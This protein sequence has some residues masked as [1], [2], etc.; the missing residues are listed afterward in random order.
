[1]KKKISVSWSGGKDS[2]FALYKI[3][4]ADEFHVVS[5]HTVFNAE[6]R[7]VGMHGV[8]ESLIEEQA[9]SLKLPLE[10]LFLDVSEDHAAYTN[11]IRRYYQKC[12]ANGVEGVVFG[13]IFLEDLKIFRDKL[14]QETGLTG[15][16]PLWKID[17]KIL[18]HDFI[19]LGFK[20]MICSANANYFTKSQMGEVIDA[21]FI[22]A[23]PSNVD[24]CG[25]NGEF[26]TFV[27][28]GPIFHHPIKVLKG[29]VVERKYS[30]KILDQNG[31]EVL[32]ETPFWFQDII[33]S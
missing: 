15:F 17:S 32:Q 18:I 30:F 1:M 33:L 14:L 10:K 7:R 5:L 22:N 26:H 3:L 31:E 29:E 6:T 12:K 24:P 23:L 27:F 2:A 11:L 13:D 8:H 21:N 20:T 28:N 9:A 25:E 4:S 16:Y 19:N